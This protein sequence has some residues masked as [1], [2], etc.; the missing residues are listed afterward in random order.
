MRVSQTWTVIKNK[1]KKRNEPE[2]INLIRGEECQEHYRQLVT[3]NN[4][5][6]KEQIDD[7]ELDENM[8]EDNVSV[9]EIKKH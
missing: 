6:F 4:I 5:E 1:R 8:Q 3:K 9:N 7:I 2:I